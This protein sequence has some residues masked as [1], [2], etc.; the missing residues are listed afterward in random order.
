MR[1]LNVDPQSVEMCVGVGLSQW[2][3]FMY[4]VTKQETTKR[5]ICD[6]KAREEEHCI[7]DKVV[8]LTSRKE[9]LN[10][11]GYCEERETVVKRR[12]CECFDKKLHHKS[13]KPR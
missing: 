10:A 12:I 6:S 5:C 4:Q 11:D 13:V 9:V 7:G 2:Q 1:L 3:H 8:R